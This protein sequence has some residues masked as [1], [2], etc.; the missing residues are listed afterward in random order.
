[1][2]KKQASLTNEVLKNYSFLSEMYE[3]SYFPKKCVDKAK[4]ILID[5]CFQI[6][7]MKPRN[8]EELY[9]LTHSA[10]DKFNDLQEYFDENDS[11]IETAARESIGEDFE[12]IAH[13]YGFE[14]ADTEELIATREW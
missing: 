9:K 1:M 4:D 13:S 10:T 14:N 8:L 11:E 2:K 12:F 6:E 5:L 7:E 3:D